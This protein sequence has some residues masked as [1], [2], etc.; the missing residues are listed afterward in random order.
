M[1]DHILEIDWNEKTGWAKPKIS[2]YKP[3]QID[4]A[5]S[6]LHYAL[7]CFEG[8]KA[9]PHVNGKDINLFR[10]KDNMKRMNNSF[11]KLAFPNFDIDEAIK[12]I[13]ELVKLDKE[14][15][16]RKYNHSLYIRPTGIAMENTLGVKPT[17]DVKFF[18][19]ISPVGPYYPQGFKPVSVYCALDAVRAW[20][21]GNGD[22][23]LGANYG[24]TIQ[25]ALKV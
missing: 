13:I 17:S 14:W 16:P 24:P 12:S 22:K 3:F 1:T 4:P 10:A 7:E 21:N 25:P 19:I 9:Y 18:A 23:K 15:I 5:N 11:E 20:P 2:A 8:M 6:T